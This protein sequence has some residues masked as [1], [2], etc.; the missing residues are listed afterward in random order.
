[1][2]V[3]YLMDMV[4]S[5]VVHDNSSITAVTPLVR[6][7]GDDIC[8][9]KL[10]WC[11]VEKCSKMDTV[12]TNNCPKVSFPEP[13]TFWAVDLLVARSIWSKRVRRDHLQGSFGALRSVHIHFCPRLIFVL[14]LP[15]SSMCCL[16]ILQIIC[17]GDL[18]HVF[19]AEAEILNKIFTGPRRGVLEFPNLKHIYLYELPK[20][21]QICEAKMFAPYLKTITVKGCWSLKRLPVTN[22]LS[23]GDRSDNCPS[24]LREGLVGEAGVGRQGTR[25]PPFPL[26]VTPSTIRG[27][28]LEVETIKGCGVV[29]WFFVLDRALPLLSQVSTAGV[30]FFS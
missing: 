23:K 19:P 22:L 14:P 3:I 7:K 6:G 15:W 12:F 9:N 16:E 11:H 28:G 13:E 24:G 21:H 27:K 2:A 10:K 18:T 30:F 26:Q 4:E 20:L 8:W 29:P 1:E 17:C 5:L 25:P